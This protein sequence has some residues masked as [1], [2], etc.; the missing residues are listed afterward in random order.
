MLKKE[1]ISKIIIY[2]P[3]W[4]QFRL[5]RATSS[6]WVT[7]MS[8]KPLGDAAM[9]YI[10]QKVGEELTGQS[11]AEDDSIEDENTIWGLTNEPLA[12]KLLQEVK[13]IEFLATQNIIFDVNERFSSTPDAI[14][15]HGESISQLEYNVSTVEIKCPRKYHKYI[16]LFKCKTPAHLKSFNKQYYWQVLDQMHICDSAVGYF[17]CF[18][19]LFPEGANHNIIEFRKM[20]L[21]DDFKLIKQRKKLFIDSFE[22]ERSHMIGV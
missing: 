10:F 16:P 15:I 20:D 4:H 3:E 2:S 1:Q 18:H 9:T 14:W 22:Q 12:L 8:E 21:W 17:M 13:Q 6:K 5:G 11:T 19:P 7:Q